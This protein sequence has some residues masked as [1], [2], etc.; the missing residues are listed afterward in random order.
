M[1]EEKKLIVS[2]WKLKI[3][4]KMCQ[5]VVDF[6]QYLVGVVGIILMNRSEKG[7]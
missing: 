5:F 6:A 1:E 3:L 7:R 4:F 2:I